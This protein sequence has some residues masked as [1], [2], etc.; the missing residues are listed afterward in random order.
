MVDTSAIVAF[1][2][3]RDRQHVAVRAWLE[4]ETDDLA[5]TPMI[6]AEADHLVASRG[7]RAASAALR[8]D[9]AAGAYSVEWWP[10]AMSAAVRVADRY[11]DMD[12]GLADA[13]LVILAE[14]MG[15]VDVATLDERH[16]R[17]LRPLSGGHAFRLLPVDI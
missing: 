2:N 13:S 1:M 7:G 11:A 3:A 9:L 17:A 14:R 10:A 8:A 16:F 12:L 6:V 15:T 4:A 5:T